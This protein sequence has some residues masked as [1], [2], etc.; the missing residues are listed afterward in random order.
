MAEMWRI[1]W[2][3]AGIY[4]AGSEV[5]SSGKE[6]F[7][8]DVMIGYMVWYQILANHDNPHAV[9]FGARELC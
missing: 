3:K 8:N 4:D 1:E 2:Q 9:T 5:P 7:V 6:V